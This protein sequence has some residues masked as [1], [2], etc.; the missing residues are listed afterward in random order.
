MN[1]DIL[2]ADA[3]ITYRQLDHWIN[4]G[5]ISDGGNPGSGV[6]RDFSNP[7]AIEKVRLMGRLTRAGF[8][9]KRASDIADMYFDHTIPAIYI[10][11]GLYLEI[12]QHGYV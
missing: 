2:C 6:P 7:K 11:P 5:W 12:T 8:P 1:S 9:A 10:G 4:K 3:G